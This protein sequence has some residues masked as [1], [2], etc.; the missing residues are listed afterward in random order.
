MTIFF[1]IVAALILL[2]FALGARINTTESYPV[3][4]YWTAGDSY[5]K[6]DLVTFCP[7]LSEVVEEGRRLGVLTT[8]FCNGEH[9]LLIKKVA[10]VSGDQVT[11]D[12]NG[13]F[14]NG[15]FIPNSKPLQVEGISIA[16]MNK[17]TVADSEVLTMSDYNSSSFDSRYY[18]LV[19]S[20]NIKSKVIPLYVE[21][22]KES[23]L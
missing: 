21:Q 10:A 22:H 8:G 15:V 12:N 3:G 13:V 1:L 20:M 11:I 5:Q 16:Y 7:P 2:M 6:G 17:Y 4:L 23:E 19:P 18:G 9:G 14:V